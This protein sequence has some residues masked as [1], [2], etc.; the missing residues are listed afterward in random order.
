M[1]ANIHD[2]DFDEIQGKDKKPTGYR[3]TNDANK[4]EMHTT[5]LKKILVSAASLKVCADEKLLTPKIAWELS[6]TKTSGFTPLGT[7][8]NFSLVTGKAKSRKSFFIN[9]AVSAAVGKE[10]S[11]NRLRSDLPLDQNEVLY[12]DTEQGRYHVQLALLRICKQT[13]LLEPKNLHVYSLRSKSPAERLQIIEALIYENDRI[14][15]VVI[16]G[17]KDLVTSINDEEQAT[18]IA[19]KL[20][21]WSEERG[22]H[23]VTVLHQNKGDTNARGHLGTELI[24]K[25]ET[26]LAVSKSETNNAFSIVEPQQCRNIEPES[27]AF[28]IVDELPVIVEGYDIRGARK[29]SKLDVTTIEDSKVY[30]LLEEVFK[31]E[32]RLKY[33]KLRQQIQIAYKFKFATDLSDN[34]AK[35]LLTSC[36][37]KGWLLQERKN[38]EYTL[39]VYQTM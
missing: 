23:I 32:N 6:N 16:D 11:L 12:F 39:G 33:T 31:K 17:I 22:I 2:L 19:S 37:E 5:I 1:S 13:G 14:G 26:V 38:S 35:T 10:L 7:L 8:G 25:A 30:D 24:N 21:K 27:F 20:L 28:E 29:S 36:K 9:I 4:L 3:Q 34:K 15:F 18:M